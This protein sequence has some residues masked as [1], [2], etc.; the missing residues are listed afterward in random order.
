MQKL[1]RFRACSTVCMFLILLLMLVG[2]LRVADTATDASL[3]AAAETQNTARI[4]VSRQRGTVF[5]T[6]M[7]PLTNTQS[8][9]VTVVSPYADAQNALKG[10]LSAE[11]LE[12]LR[13][14]L[15]QGKPVLVNTEEAVSGYGISNVT[16]AVNQSAGSMASHLLGYTDNTGHGVC[17]VQKA[18]DA[19]LYSG[20]TVDVCFVQDS[21]GRMVEKFGTEI[22][23]KSGAELSG[24]K[25]TIDADIQAAV[26]GIAHDL[27]RGA[28]VISEVGSGKI[29][30]LVSRP[31]YDAA[32]VAAYLSREDS[33]LLN[34]AFCAYNVGSV[35]KPCVAAAAMESGV[36]TNRLFECTGSF[37][38]DQKN[39]VCH[40]KNGHGMVDLYAAL[41]YSCNTY[42][43]S[44]A[45]Q[46]GADAICDMASVL[47]FGQRCYFADSLF[48]DKGNVPAASEHS[49][50]RS[51]ANLAI[52]QGDL[53]LTPVSML[54][55][56]EAI[57]DGG[58]YHSPSLVEDYVSNGK[59]LGVLEEPLPTRAM[60][61]ET[62]EKI[63]A[64]LEN[65]VENGTGLAAK[66]KLCTAAGKT[67]TAQT[68]WI[69]NGRFV[70]HSW[71][72]GYF[73][74]DNPR[75]VAVI[76]SEDTNGGGTPCSPLFARV[77]DAV[78]KLKLS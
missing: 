3:K 74:A 19:V 63:G 30:A 1:S 49:S 78:F 24:V 10:V 18:F 35:F 32:N 14:Q 67:A 4:T 75:Y 57:A 6:N 60:S 28:I 41:T 37:T 29:R 16:V 7:L 17:G 36:V 68:G 31:N 11:E 69:E 26:E 15:T 22:K 52:G 47:G 2:F 9:N 61:A 72:C 76:I 12:A 71:F 38:V 55:L 53:M 40:K 21:R 77:A 23:F 8:Q 46:T 65:V 27:K 64:A 39:F 50:Q 48:T 45:L 66:P 54:T 13:E 62:A 51:L 42:F 5:D 73:P 56:Y 43:Y 20:S 33:P 34:R 44:L 25:L 58:V 70:E 59:P